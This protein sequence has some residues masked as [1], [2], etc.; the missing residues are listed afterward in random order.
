MTTAVEVPY[1][2][3]ME[4][5][6]RLRQSLLGDFDAC[7]LSARFGLETEYLNADDPK[8]RFRW[9]TAPQSRGTIFHRWAARL[10]N[11]LA[12]IPADHLQAEDETRCTAC[13][14]KQDRMEWQDGAQPT[15]VERC[16]MC[17][18]D[19]LEPLTVDDVAMELLGDTLRQHDVP[20]ADVVRV[21]AQHLKDLEWVV[22]KFAREQRFPNIQHTLVSV[23]ERLNA[24]LDYP[25]KLSPGAVVLR[26]LSGQLDALFFEVDADGSIHA[27]VLDWKDTWAIPGATSLS[28]EGYWQQRFY[29]WLVMMNFPSVSRVTLR[30]VYVRFSGGDDGTENHRQATIGRARLPFIQRELAISAESFDRAYEADA[31]LRE[32]AAAHEI[33][34]G[35][36]SPELLERLKDQR[37]ER[38]MLFSPTPGHHCFS[39]DTRLLT[40]RGPMTLREA[41]GRAV[42]VLNRHGQWE[43]ATVRS[44]GRQPLVRVVFDDGTVVRAT[45]DHRWWRMAGRGREGWHQTAERITTMELDRAPLVTSNESALDPE[46]IR[47]GVVFGDGFVRRDRGWS[48]VR[49]QPHKAELARFFDNSPRSVEHLPG[50]LIEHRPVKRRAGGVVEVTMQPAHY[51]ALPERLTPAYARGF[52]AGLV[53]TDGKVSGRPASGVEIHCEGRERAELIAEMAWMG[54]CAVSSVRLSSDRPTNYSPVGTATRELMAIRL[55]P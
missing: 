4:R 24:T 23:E 46:G 50:Q 27:I 6:P 29:A 39:G 10:L 22:R 3:A 7:A 41:S 37:A 9:S 44:F 36:A 40:D 2:R 53:A 11:V 19:Q 25:N 31:I 54:G 18:S 55:K 48:M 49:L 26:E 12:A 21:P 34:E 17:G 38:D 33:V 5:F 30:E 28:E 32:L 20:A 45:P 42:G 52:I 35:D 1:P 43:D 8:R 15:E 13:G 47:H 16:Q 51:K 14:N